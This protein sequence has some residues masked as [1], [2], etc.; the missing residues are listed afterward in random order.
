MDLPKGMQIVA[1]S[2]LNQNRLDEF[3]EKGWKPYLDYRQMLESRDVD[4]VIVA[5]PDHWHASTL[6]THAKPARMCT[7]RSP[8]R[9]PC[10]KAGRWWRPYGRTIAC[11]KRQSTASMEQCC[12]GCEL[13]RNGRLGKVHTVHGTTIRV[14]GMHVAGTARAEGLNWDMWLGQ[15]P[16]RPYH[17]E[18]YLPRVRG[19][20]PAGSRSVPIP[21]ER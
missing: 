16:V 10:V 15:T 6:F 17:E 11:S 1:I 14:R 20:E 13:V 21:A 5:T 2:D 12:L 8:C 19:T 18:L 4:A 7:A 9:L 3:K